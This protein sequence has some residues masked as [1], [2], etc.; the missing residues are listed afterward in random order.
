V[1]EPTDID[2]DLP[3][4]ITHDSADLPLPFRELVE[5]LVE[6]WVA[7]GEHVLMESHD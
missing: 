6:Y 1:Q 4:R 3:L 7:G 2:D 5:T